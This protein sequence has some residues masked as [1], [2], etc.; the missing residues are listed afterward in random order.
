MAS[1]RLAWMVANELLDIKVAVPTN[2]EGEPIVLRGIY[3]ESEGIITDR[4]SNRLSFS[5]CLANRYPRPTP[6]RS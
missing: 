5:L 2:A 6:P 1:K 3:H 4:A